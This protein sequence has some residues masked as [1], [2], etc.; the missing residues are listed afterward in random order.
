MKAKDGMSVGKKLVI[1]AAAIV[2]VLL[3]AYFIVAIYFNSHVFPNTYIQEVSISGESQAGIEKKINSML[4]DYSLVLITREDETEVIDC[5]DVKLAFVT[6]D[7]GEKLIA[8]QNILE[9]P[10]HLFEKTVFT[11]KFD[12]QYDEQMLD[13]VIGSLECVSSTDVVQPEDAYIADYVSGEGFK[14]LPE[15]PGNTID[16][17]ALKGAVIDALLSMD[18][19]IDLDEEGCYVEPGVYSTD[20]DIT[21][22]AE[23]LNRFT[24]TRI[25]YTF[26][27]DE[28][29]VDGDVVY[30]WMNISKKGKVTIDTDKVRAFVDSLGSKYDTIFRTRKFVTTYGK[31][32]TLSEGDYGW[33]MNR[34]AETEELVKLVKKGKQ[35]N[36]K[37]VYYQE[38]SQYG[39]NDYGNTYVEIN[40]TAQHLYVYKDGS[41]VLE[42][43]FVSGKDTPD[44]RTPSG[45]YGI[46][47]KERDATLVGED[48]ETPVSYWM[49]FNKHIGMHDAIWRNRFGANLYKAGG[50]HGCINLP[51]YVAEKIY[52][53]VEKGTPVIC[54]ELAGTESTSTTA[55]GDKEIAQFV[56]DAIDRI[57]NVVQ[58]RKNA[59]E[60][61]LKR[62]RDSYNGLTSNQKKYVTNLNKLEKAEKEFKELQ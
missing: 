28:V 50:S 18:D 32:I 7:Y 34:A 21:E 10:K 52:N 4:D 22:Q 1:T 47:Y 9:W 56:V 53:I 30:E 8:A 19:E 31:E 48:Y 11:S 15:V 5:A 42:S 33:W 17:D 44:R 40:L 51:F 6:E 2:V 62:I 41:M 57:G 37:P 60:K 20:E 49:P 38:A 36:R 29:V 16:R 13:D 24:D 12:M 45:V 26:G 54:Y 46:T 35:E 55:Q 39:A 14:I 58:S 43:D 61:T 27:D 23:Y 3:A 59:L 25:V